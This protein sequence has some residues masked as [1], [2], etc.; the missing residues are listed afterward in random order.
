MGFIGKEFH[1]FLENG[2][3]NESLQLYKPIY[4]SLVSFYA[5]SY[6]P[7]FKEEDI[8]NITEQE[9]SEKEKNLKNKF[10]N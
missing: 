10:V 8:K 9:I 7:S 4:H 5:N 2:E 6:N 1:K 3:I